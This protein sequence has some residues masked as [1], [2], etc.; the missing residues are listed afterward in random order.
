MSKFSAPIIFLILAVAV[1]FLSPN[2]RFIAVVF[3]VFAVLSLLL[4]PA[5]ARFGRKIDTLKQIID[6]R[7]K[8]NRP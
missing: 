8:Q 3:V 2:S 4:V 7:E 6:E 5:S 1:F